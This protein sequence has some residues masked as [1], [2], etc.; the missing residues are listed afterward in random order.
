MKS[1]VAHY[2]FKIK[3][4]LEKFLDSG[5]QTNIDIDLDKLLDYLSTQEKAEVEATL[6]TLPIFTEWIT[7]AV[8]MWSTNRTTPTTNIATFTLNLAS[9]LSKNENRFCSLNNNNFFIK[10]VNVSKA[11]R[12]EAAPTVKLAY[13]KLL[14]SFLEHKS[15]IEWM[16]ACSFWEDIFEL[17]LTV[18]KVDITRD[19]CKFM[20]KILEQTIDHDENFCNNIVKRIMLPLGET[21]YKSIEI[22]AEEIAVTNETV[23]QSLSP[24]LQLIGNI[25]EY[26]LEGILFAQKDFRVAL[27]FSKNFH[28]KERISDFMLI[29]HN[30][31]LVFDLGKI[32]FIMQF[33]ELYVNVICNNFNE[34]D[35]RSSIDKINNFF[36]ANISKGNFEDFLKFCNFGHL[37]WNL[38]AS[39]ILHTQV[40]NDNKAISFANQLVLLNLMPNFCLTVKYCYSMV[41]CEEKLLAD[42]YR[43]DLLQKV[44]KTMDQQ[45]ILTKTFFKENG[46]DGV[47]VTNLLAERFYLLYYTS[48]KKLEIVI[49]EVSYFSLLFEVIAIFIEEFAITWKDG[50]E[51]IHV[52][53]VSFEFLSIPNWPAEVVIKAL[54]L[55]NIS[56][57]KYMTPNLALLV[58]RT[59]DSTMALLGPLLY[60]K[61]LDESQVKKSALE[62]I[63]TISQMSSS[64]K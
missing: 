6:I 53:A 34:K 10:L 60:S 9:L 52:L 46:S 39:K 19:S 47:S 33:L 3:Q 7:Q 48:P 58:D 35:V 8:A 4:L 11:R 13:M 51:A 62:V 16:I 26:F 41:E 30:K 38:M 43:D 23:S 54:K 59:T 1:A 20:S 2:Q 56:I 37:Y 31:C 18:E 25:L 49:N 5:C 63:Y 29:A 32:V 55:I 24:T 36:V 57:A 42:E 64:S 28:L 45:V 61:L 14:S 22:F 17:S 12:P 44:Y 40:N 27:I 50:I 21:I 15:G